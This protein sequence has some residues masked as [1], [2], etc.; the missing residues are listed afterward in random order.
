LAFDCDVT[1]QEQLAKVLETVKRR[2]Q[3][4]DI[5]CSNAG[6]VFP[7]NKNDDNVTKH[8]TEQWGKILQVNLLSHVT[9]LRL[10]LPDWESG[11]GD[12]IF[13]MT[14]SAAGLLT[15]VGDASYGVTKAAAVSLAEH[16]AISH[17]DV[18][19]VH[20]LC[21]QA[22]DTPFIADTKG[23]N[24]AMTDGVISPEFVAGCTLDAM[25]KK[26]FFIFPHPEVPTYFE[27]K[28]KD[29]ARWLKGMQRLR[30]RMMQSK[31]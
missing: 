19:Q 14:A 16:L 23:I 28:A 11:K 27:R 7:P 13:C 21:P 25:R 17:G 29:H 12:G 31:L 24:A 20:C 26:E 10:L 15:M 4:I 5:Y 22:V 9:A 3:R 30:N 1:D 6:I 8:S 2:Y 18:V